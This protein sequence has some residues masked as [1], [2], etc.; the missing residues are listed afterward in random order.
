VLTHFHT[1]YLVTDIIP[2]SGNELDLPLTVDALREAVRAPRDR[3]E[4]TQRDQEKSRQILQNF[5]NKTVEQLTVSLGRRLDINASEQPIPNGDLGEEQQPESL[6]ET[7]QRLVKR[8]EEWT[9]MHEF[10]HPGEEVKNL[11]DIK[12]PPTFIR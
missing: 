9:K 4:E 5:R 12:F 2:E 6:A 1:V 7:I 11:F 3:V 8:N 10:A